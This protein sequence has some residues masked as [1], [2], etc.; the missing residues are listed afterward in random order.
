MRCISSIKTTICIAPLIFDWRTSNS[1]WLMRNWVSGSVRYDVIVPKYAFFACLRVLPLIV[2]VVKVFLVQSYLRYICCIKQ[3]YGIIYRVDE[4][5]DCVGY[6][7]RF[8][9][10]ERWVLFEWRCICFFGWQHGDCIGGFVLNTRVM[11]HFKAKLPYLKL[12][13]REWAWNVGKI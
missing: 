3:T 1:L 12:Q 8:C 5:Y 4:I 7:A 2:E 6:V 13:L 11:D 9:C 10:Q